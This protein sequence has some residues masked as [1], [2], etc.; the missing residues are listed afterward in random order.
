VSSSDIA[1]VFEACNP[2]ED[3][4]NGSLQEDQFAAPLSTVAHYRP[5]DVLDLDLS[6]NVLGESGDETQQSELSDH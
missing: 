1:S 5:R 4:L 2:R 6:P 3:V